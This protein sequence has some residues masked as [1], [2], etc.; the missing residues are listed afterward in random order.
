MSG[1]SLYVSGDGFTE[2]SHVILNNRK[3]NTKYINENLLAI[4]GDS[5]NGDF[6]S[7]RVSQINN[8][9]VKL[10]TTEEYVINNKV[11]DDI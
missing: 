3:M 5:L 1:D 9:L 7:V 6:D 10:S 11:Q 2:F 4:S 8:E